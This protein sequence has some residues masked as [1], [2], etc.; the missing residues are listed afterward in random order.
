MLGR[1]RSDGHQCDEF[2]PSSA[3][4][5]GGALLVVATRLRVPPVLPRLQA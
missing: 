3:R 1:D 4:L 2:G 5:G